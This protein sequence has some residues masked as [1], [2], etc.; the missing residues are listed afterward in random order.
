MKKLD[1]LHKEIESIQAEL[2]NLEK[3]RDTTQLRKFQ[4]QLQGELSYL[5]QEIQRITESEE[6]KL[7][8]KQ[9]L[10]NLANQTRSSKNKRTWNYIKSIQ[11]N[12]H[13]NKSL[14]EIRTS[15]R[16]HREGLE[17]DIPDVAWRNPSP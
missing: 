11:K 12:Y 2:E 3:F 16:K 8:R 14:K 6:Q 7:Q 5:K 10:E 1:K 17:T 15:L 13:P 9:L 4:R